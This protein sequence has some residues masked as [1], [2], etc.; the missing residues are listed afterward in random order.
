MFYIDYKVENL[1]LYPAMRG[2]FCQEPAAAAHLS[3]MMGYK[4]KEVRR[5]RKTSKGMYRGLISTAMYVVQQE[6]LLDCW[7]APCMSG[8][9]YTE[10]Q[11]QRF[12]VW[13]EVTGVRDNRANRV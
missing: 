10:P 13:K 12:F 4:W 11:E 5:K 9:F 7:T 2:H 8:R 1:K 3:P 6:Y